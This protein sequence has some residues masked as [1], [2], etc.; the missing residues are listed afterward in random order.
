MLLVWFSLN[1]QDVQIICPNL[2]GLL[3]YNDILQLCWCWQ[4]SQTI[5]DL[6]SS[7]FNS[8]QGAYNDGYM[9]IFLVTLVRK[10]R[11]EEKLDVIECMI[12]SLG[13]V[14]AQAENLRSQIY[15]LPSH[16][17][18]ETWVALLGRGEIGK[19]FETPCQ[20]HLCSEGASLHWQVGRKLVSSA[21]AVCSLFVRTG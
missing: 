10:K 7:W 13:Q 11:S 20:F 2:P 8:Y 4:I 1:Y 14:C 5:A 16:L 21:A 17:C 12:Q 6:G 3:F 19:G 18:S 9:C 15:K